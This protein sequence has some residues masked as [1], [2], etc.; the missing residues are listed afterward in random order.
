MKTYRLRLSVLVLL[1]AGSNLPAQDPGSGFDL[2]ALKQALQATGGGTALQGV[3]AIPKALM[4]KVNNSNDSQKNQPAQDHTIEDDIRQMKAREKGPK[5]FASDL[6]EFRDAKISDT[7][8]GIAED[9]VLGVG[10]QLQ[11]NVFGSATFELPL[12]VDGRGE[13]IIPKVGAVKVSGLSLAK[14][15]AAL[16]AKVAKNFSRTTV[17]L[18]VTQLREV[19]VFVLGEVYKPGSFLV[20][21]L[22]SLV[23]VLG[24]AGGPTPVGSFRQIRVLRGGT[25]VH[26]V[27]LYPLRAEGIGNMNFSL[28]SGDT[29]FVPLAFNQILLEGAFTRV[30]AEAEAAAEAAAQAKEA[31]DPKG[32]SVQEDLEENAL[33]EA[34]RTLLH[35]IRHLEARLEV[36]AV[37]QVPPANQ[38]LPTPVTNN[39]LDLPKTSEMSP[40]DR[41]AAEDQLQQAREQLHQ[42][43]IQRRGDRRVPAQD[44]VVLERAEQPQW[45]TQ[46]QLDGKAPRMQFEALP[47]E[48]VADALR[49]AG[50]FATQA[51]AGGLSLRRMNAG[52][53]L[54]VLDVVMPEGAASTRIERGDVLSALP[55]RDRLERSVQIEGWVRVPGVFAR[56]EGLRVGDLLKREKQV[57]PDTYQGRGEIVRTA[58]DGQTSYLAFEVAK[59]LA[60]DPAHNLLLADRDRIDLYRIEDLRE[61]RT[62]TV[63]GPATR[64]GTFEF[65]E[66]MRAGDLLFRAGVL[67]QADRLVAELAHTR[68][69]KPSEVRTLD[70]TRL[71]STEQGSPVDL[72]D[73]IVNPRLEALD[74]LSV[75]EKPDYRPHRM[76]KV[77]GQVAR[78]GFYSLDKDKMGLSDLL[79]RAG[80]LTPDAMPAGAIF[81]RRLGSLDSE[82]AK[83]L[84][85]VGIQEKDPTGNGINEILSRLSETKRQPLTGQLLT[86]PVLHGLILGTASRMVVNFPALLKGDRESDVTLE[87]GDEVVIPRKSDAVYVVGET[88]SP[89][90]S[91]RVKD[92]MR[93]KEVLRLAGGTTRNADT[94]N[95]RLLKAD[96]RI[97]DS[98]VSGRKVEPGDAVLVPSKVRRDVSWQENMAAITNLAVMYAAIKK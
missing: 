90:G 51:F 94:W 82:K 77:S 28:Q 54:Q 35:Q 93:V 40:A 98:W 45:L 31:K 96:G 18:S 43:K 57:L 95:I 29:I 33:P 16:Q 53:G 46:W 38:V 63:V 42:M 75:F 11:V 91:F 13:V 83:A 41:A 37:N 71:L 66:G 59:A 1:L 47:G 64:P 30:V 72:K 39:P 69:G 27:D 9:Y 61:R 32:K 78:P 17:D 12:Q 62:V 2:Q 8:G 85:L 23:N 22:S 67:R 3:D 89:F 65:H 24:L 14:A 15:R 76:V 49:F 7:D 70:L 97:L 44:A 26:S 34:Q 21:S 81:L 4:S 6:F 86:T 52:G 50:G 80:G 48:T 5:R 10:D 92:G 84:E 88:A 25:V 87:D 36:S 79:H 73:D 58:V 20:P 60:G 68:D 19:R 74:Q 55:L 56:T